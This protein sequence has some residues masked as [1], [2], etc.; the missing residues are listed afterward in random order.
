MDPLNASPLQWLALF[1]LV[2]AVLVVIVWIRRVRRA[3]RSQPSY[4]PA[5]FTIANLAAKSG[6]AGPPPLAGLAFGDF[7]DSPAGEADCTPRWSGD[8]GGGAADF[9]TGGCDAPSVDMSSSGG[10]FD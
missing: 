7:P 6:D 4:A 1:V 5:D 8:L 2:F 3:L 10:S 9:G